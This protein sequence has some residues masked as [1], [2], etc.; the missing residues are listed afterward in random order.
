M[1]KN[2]NINFVLFYFL[3][4][5]ITNANLFDFIS[6]II[7]SFIV[8][9]LTKY[10]LRNFSIGLKLLLMVGLIIFPL[11]LQGN[12][13]I[14]L[15]PVGYQYI[16]ISL[17]SS[18][19][20]IETKKKSIISQLSLFQLSR[21]LCNAAL[22]PFTYIAGPSASL[23]E[24]K[25][26]ENY[27]ASKYKNFNLGALEKSIE[28]FLKVIL[29]NYLA[30][31]DNIFNYDL[32]SQE[33]F[34]PLKI[35]YFLTFGFYNFWKYFLLFAGASELCEA[36]LMVIRIKVIK[37]FNQPYLTTFYHEI[38]SR[39]HL[40]ITDRIRENL[41]TPITLI[42]LRKFSN[43]NPIISF[44]LIEGFP[45]LTL[46]ALIAVWH[47]GKEID[48][49][50]A[51]ISIVLTI[52]SRLISRNSKLNNILKKNYFIKEFISFISISVFGLALSIYSLNVKQEIILYRSLEIK[53]NF[54]ILIFLILINLYLRYKSSF[55]GEINKKG[56]HEERIYFSIFEFVFSLSFIS[57]GLIPLQTG[58]D[59]LYYGN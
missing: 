16:S 3:Y 19:I 21:D 27:K 33:N 48:M 14:I 47:G 29:G 30:S 54:L 38:W 12:Y 45:A 26:E 4:W 49:I 59:F 35:I 31:L 5:L 40:N 56:F 39:W 43:L 1:I 32:I 11:M 24:I 10:L 13:K 53:T 57:S 42:S 58:L 55:L 36:F 34:F 8:A 23:E 50:F 22:C 20:F 25:I 6:L 46:F 51:V 28:G 9:T 44:I 37:N 7:L 2:Q 17:I 15:L 41:F 18:L 52:M